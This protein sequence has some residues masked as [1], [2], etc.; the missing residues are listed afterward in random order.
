MKD[1]FS[2]IP[3]YEQVSGKCSIGDAIRLDAKPGE[4]SVTRVSGRFADITGGKVYEI[5][6]PCRTE[7]ITVGKAQAIA[8]WIKENGD[9]YSRCY[10]EKTAD[11]TMKLRCCPHESVNALEI[12]YRLWAHGGGTALFG[13]PEITCMG[14]Y[15]PRK[16]RLATAWVNTHKD[17]R[18][19]A[20]NLSE[21]L[22]I[23]DNAGKSE[24]KPDLLV[25]SETIYGRNVD[26]LTRAEKAPAL[27]SEPVRLICGK[28]AEHKMYI[29]V[30]MLINDGGLLKNVAL[31]INRMGKVE[32][33]YTKTHLT[34]GEIESGIVPGMEIPVYDLDFGRVGVL[35]CW[36][37]YFSETSRILHLKGA[38]VI[39]VPTAGDTDYQC[40]ARAA[41]SGAYLVMSGMH[42]PGSSMILDPDG[43]TIASVRDLRQCYASAEVDLNQRNFTYWLSVGPCYGEARDIYLNER[44]NDL[45]DDIN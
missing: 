27:D 39:A 23:A 15:Q 20:D 38:E 35:I 22:R 7:G 14:D 37:H 5:T 30:G 44:R 9:I 12:E 1:I 3:I 10:F 33:I 45:Y 6:V 4:Y 8:S 24:E 16:A 43:N 40:R 13:A 18:T 36:D 31:I 19:L 32:H 29:I 42:M 21:I 2:A 25:F 41:D 26:N 11:D 28:A 17:G 34:M